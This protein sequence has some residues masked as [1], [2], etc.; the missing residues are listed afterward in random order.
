M[1]AD[2]QEHANSNTVLLTRPCVRCVPL[3]LQCASTRG[4]S[5]CYAGCKLQDGWQPAAM[6]RVSRQPKSRHTPAHSLEYS[7]RYPS[8]PSS[9]ETHPRH[10][11]HPVPADFPFFSPC[12]FP[13]RPALQHYLLDED[14]PQIDVRR[15]VVM[16]GLDLGQVA[17]ARCHLHG[18]LPCAE[19]FSNQTRL[20]HS[21]SPSPLT[22]RPTCVSNCEPWPPR[23]RKT[24]RLSRNEVL[25]AYLIDPPCCTRALLTVSTA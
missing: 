7:R 2:P 13:T 25:F 16:H 1:T 12:L 11:M 4:R 22:P 15:D 21:T 6:R 20:L 19:Y 18:R 23:L 10:L 5:L 24:L 8:W 9:E 3:F 17:D 14:K